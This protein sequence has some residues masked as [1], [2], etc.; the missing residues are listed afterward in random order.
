[1]GRPKKLLR[2]SKFSRS[3]STVIEI[4]IP[5]LAMAKRLPE[6]RKIV[7]GIIIPGGSGPM[8]IKFFPILAGFRMVIRGANSQQEFFVYTE[9]APA[10]QASLQKIWDDERR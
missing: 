5:I 9:N 1:M 6:V 10:T 7:I 8:R 4:A 2:G 3:H